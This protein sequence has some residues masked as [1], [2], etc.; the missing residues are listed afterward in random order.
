[1]AGVKSKRRKT[2]VQIHKVFLFTNF[3]FS[4]PAGLIWLV[5]EYKFSFP[6][7]WFLI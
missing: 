3:L 1:M 4:V 5:P 2:K 7:V 6:F